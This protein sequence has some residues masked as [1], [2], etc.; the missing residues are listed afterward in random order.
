[1]RADLVINPCKDGR[2][3]PSARACLRPRQLDRQPGFTLS[4][5]TAGPSGVVAASWWTLN[6]RPR[7]SPDE[8]RGVFV[9]VLTL[10]LSSE[11][12]MPGQQ[13][14]TG[15]GTV[16]PASHRPALYGGRAHR[17][18]KLARSDP[19]AWRQLISCLAASSND[20][21]SFCH[22]LEAAPSVF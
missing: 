22:P 8:A 16:P 10:A 13:E 4:V 21:V 18:P 1:M 19:S 3:R 2:R 11:S 20:S 14:P 6:C 15:C 12:A 17:S 9:D 7:P 5:N